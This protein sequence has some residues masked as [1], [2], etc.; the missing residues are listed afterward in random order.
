MSPM[1][2]FIKRMYETKRSDGT[3]TYTDADIEQLVLL[4]RIT[5]EEGV[6]IKKF[7]QV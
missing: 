4:G 2:S 6:E 1:Y 5:P 3:Y 7:E